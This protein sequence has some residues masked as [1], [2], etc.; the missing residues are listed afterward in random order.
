V[1]RTGIKH[2][3]SYN[4]TNLQDFHLFPTVSRRWTSET[5]ARGD[6]RAVS[7]SLHSYASFSNFGRPCTKVKGHASASFAQ[8]AS[9]VVGISDTEEQPITPG[10]PYTR[11]GS[12]WAV[13]VPFSLRAVISGPPFRCVLSF[14]GPL[15]RNTCSQAILR[16]LKRH[17]LVPCKTGGAL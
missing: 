11:R 5:F 9:L 1:S 10:E 16:E 6:I 12:W 17:F 3:R 2:R 13:S 14:L 7:F 8:V 15:V 4:A